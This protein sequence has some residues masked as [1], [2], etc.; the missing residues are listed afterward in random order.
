M[1]G[2]LLPYQILWLKDRSR[3]KIALKARQIGFSFTIA[4]EGLLEAL[5]Y[6]HAILFLSASQRQSYELFSKVLMHGR[7]LSLGSGK[8][9]DNSNRFGCTLVNGSKLLFLPANP[10]TVR[11]FTGSVYLDEFA[12]HRDSVKL[13]RAIMP[14]VSRGNNR[15]RIISTPAGDQGQFFNLWIGKNNFSKHMIDIY[16]AIDE[17][18]TIDLQAIKALNSDAD[19]FAQEFE[20]KFLSDRESYFSLPLI[21]PCVLGDL[22]EYPAGTVYVGVDI[23][24]K[25]DRTVI[26]TLIKANGA[27]WV[28][29]LEVLDKIPFQMQESILSAHIDR[30][31]PKLVYID[32]T[33]NGA[34]LAE[35][36]SAA[37]KCVE[38][39]VFTSQLKESF[40]VTVRRLLQDRSIH[41]P[42]DRALISDIH[43]IKRSVTAAGNITY[44]ADR[45]KTGHAD[46]FW[47]LALAVHAASQKIVVAA[48]HSRDRE[49]R[50]SLFSR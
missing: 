31:K 25:K 42:N 18:H 24:R 4:L 28:K 40:V 33:G 23:G 12:F 5:E 34:H 36:L 45:D 41:I 30:V 39:I 19:T 7:A 37:F 13:F 47:A 2:L 35:N 15:L 1:P 48:D 46:R 3:F 17:G 27:L 32:A 49:I 43:S 6:R 38:G 50:P 8:I 44:V 26:I 21:Y 10:D 14:T 11:G 22:T 29:P 20:C 16:Q 9:I